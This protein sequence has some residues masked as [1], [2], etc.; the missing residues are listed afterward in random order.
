ML[1]PERLIAHRGW[2]R[3]YPENTLIG[4][5]AA[6]AAGARHVEIDIQLTADHIAVLFHDAT[7]SRVCGVDQSIFSLTLEELGEVSAYE[8]QRLG[9]RFIGTPISTLSALI[10]DIE[11]HA[12][13]TLYVEIKTESL[14]QFGHTTVLNAVLPHL[15]SVR[16]RCYV[17]S[18]DLAILQQARQ[19]GW[20]LIA[21][22]LTQLSQLD[23][24]LMDQLKPDMV[25]CNYKLLSPGDLQRRF[26][27]PCALYEIDHYDD[28][29]NWLA[30]GAHL[31]ESFA[32]GELLAAHSG[33]VDE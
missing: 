7:L 6:I 9:E 21:P 27:Y 5:D 2:Q 1:F 30:E 28:A 25:F 15:Q 22:V 19:A 33:A 18:F 8:P 32:I 31:I 10:A 4:V 23:S 29:C 12:D 17:I 3:H 20:P 16:S 13:V 24:E 26:A 11:N 14:N